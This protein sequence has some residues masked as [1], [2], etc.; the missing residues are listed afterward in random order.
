[1]RQ[2]NGHRQQGEPRKEQ[3]PKDVEA[4][5]PEDTDHGGQD[6][7]DH[8]DLHALSAQ[9]QGSKGRIA[10]NACLFPLPVYMSFSQLTRFS[11]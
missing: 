8:E 10:A 11:Y 4:Q 1:M 3:D 2:R 6:K 7:N 5:P 9:R